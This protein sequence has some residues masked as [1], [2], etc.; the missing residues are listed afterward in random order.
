[1]ENNN[2]SD[3][4]LSNENQEKNKLQNICDD[5][6]KEYVKMIENDILKSRNTS[7]EIKTKNIENV[8]IYNK[9]TQG[10][11]FIVAEQG[12][13]NPAP[14][15]YY[16]GPYFNSEDE[17]FFIYGEKVNMENIDDY[18][19]NKELGKKINM[20]EEK[21]FGVKRVESGI[22]WSNGMIAYNKDSILIR[23]GDNEYGQP[24][25]LRC[26]KYGNLLAVEIMKRYLIQKLINDINDKKINER[27]NPKDIIVEIEDLFNNIYGE[28]YKILKGNNY[29]DIDELFSDQPLPTDIE[30][31]SANETCSDEVLSLKETI[32][33]ILE[34]MEL[35]IDKNKQLE[36]E[37][38]ENRENIRLLEEQLSKNREN[39]SLL[40]ESSKYWS[41]DCWK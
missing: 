23:E 28:K 14:I 1:M 17:Y 36:K 29:I 10:N 21:T 33:S 4:N 9:L 2:S 39:I 41:N 12:E 27:T 31:N 26:A 3:Q 30:N 16:K 20:L 11:P 22:T 24:G 19:Y 6:V 13:F 18:N 38:S 7:E 34:I 35:L 32:T 37:V 5:S 40:Q 8:N 15:N 25:F